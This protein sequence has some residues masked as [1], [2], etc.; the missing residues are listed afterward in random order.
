MAIVFYKIM[1]RGVVGLEAVENSFW[2]RES[3]L[4]QDSPTVADVVTALQKF[5]DLAAAAIYGPVTDDM[6]VTELVGIGYDKDGVPIDELPSVR[7]TSRSGTDGSARDGNSQV[8]VCRFSLSGGAVLIVG[9]KK[10]RRSYVALGPVC[11]QFISDDSALNTA[12]AAALWAASL[13]AMSLVLNQG[14]SGDMLPTRVSL[15]D[16]SSETDKVYAWRN[17]DE[18]TVAPRASYRRSRNNGR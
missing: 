10:P 7:A 11:S 18:V 5:D 17:V 4:A 15:W 9:G 3:F 2:Y 16:G 8:A 6:T 13:A 12:P 1:A 14:G